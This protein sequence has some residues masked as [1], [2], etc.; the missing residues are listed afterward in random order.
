MNSPSSS[1][2]SSLSPSSNN[3]SRRIKAGNLGVV[4]RLEFASLT[5]RAYPLVIFPFYHLRFR[6]PSPLGEQ[7]KKRI[8]QIFIRGIADLSAYPFQRDSEIEN[9]VNRAEIINETMGWVFHS[10]SPRL[11]LSFSPGTSHSERGTS[12]ITVS[13]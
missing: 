2:S 11:F 3:R 6:F 10:F 1:S 12:L 4:I 7:G 9:D 8:S 13:I 5:S